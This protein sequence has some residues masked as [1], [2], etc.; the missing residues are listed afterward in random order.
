MILRETYQKAFRLP[1]DATNPSFLCYQWTL[2][3]A[4]G[5]HRMLVSRQRGQTDII[6]ELITRANNSPQD[7]GNTPSRSPDDTL[8]TAT[9]TLATRAKAYLTSPSGRLEKAMELGRRE[10]LPLGEA[11]AG[12]HAELDFWLNRVGKT[13]PLWPLGILKPADGSK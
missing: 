11:S 13:S 6:F 9:T 10:E 5:G 2:W 7:G 12:F 4:A 3:D 1:T 8:G